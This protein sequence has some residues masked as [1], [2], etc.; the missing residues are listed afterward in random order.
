MQSAAMPAKNC[1]HCWKIEH[2]L[3]CARHCNERGRLDSFLSLFLFHA[4]FVSPQKFATQFTHW[5]VTIFSENLR[6]VEVYTV[7]TYH[8]HTLGQ[9][10][11]IKIKLRVHYSL[12]LVSIPSYMLTSIQIG[13]PQW[14]CLIHIRK[15]RSAFPFRLQYS[16]RHIAAPKAMTY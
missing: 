11:A 5:R 16:A 3:F 10:L 15:L 12:F 14:A 9:M 8:F 1:R 13:L 7:P 2:V 4:W 6:L